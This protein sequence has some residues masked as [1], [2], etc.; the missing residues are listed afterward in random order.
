MKAL[1]RVMGTIK[2][3]VFEKVQL[4]CNASS[5]EIEHL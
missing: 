1:P 5:P 3:P 4:L 2:Y